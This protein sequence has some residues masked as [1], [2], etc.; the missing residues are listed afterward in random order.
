MKNKT[1]NFSVYNRSLK[2]LYSTP[3]HRKLS[4]APQLIRLATQLS[5]ADQLRSSAM[6]ISCAAQH[7]SSATQLKI[8]QNLEFSLM[9]NFE[10]RPTGLLH[11]QNLKFL[12]N[13]KLKIFFHLPSLQTKSFP[14]MCI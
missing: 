9:F 4:D 11:N 1:E 2:T 10:I 12:C 6:Q 14:M 7:C 5:N 3:T 13:K 8:L